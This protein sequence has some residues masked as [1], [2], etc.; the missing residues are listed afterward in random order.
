ML[1]P[2]SFG[3]AAS[4]NPELCVTLLRQNVNSAVVPVASLD[5]GVFGGYHMKSIV[6][7]GTNLKSSA[8]K[9]ENCIL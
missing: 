1:P 2:L 4:E 8:A 9:I 5:F 3:L 7:T 6:R